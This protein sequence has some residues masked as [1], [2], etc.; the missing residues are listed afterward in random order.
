MRLAGLSAVSFAPAIALPLSA[1][2]AAELNRDSKGQDWITA[3]PAD[4]LQWVIMVSRVTNKRAVTP[5][6]LAGCINEMLTARNRNERSVTEMLKHN[7]LA[8]LSALCAVSAEMDAV[9]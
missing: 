9:N 2:T 6:Y 8:E 4:R 7:K 5:A 1:A 3:S